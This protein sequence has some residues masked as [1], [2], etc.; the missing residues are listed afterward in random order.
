MNTPS[1]CDTCKH[2]YYN[3]LCEDD[4][5]YMAECKKDLLMGDEKCKEYKYW[6]DCNET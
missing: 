3:V 2:L 1:P 6:E 4:P 5:S